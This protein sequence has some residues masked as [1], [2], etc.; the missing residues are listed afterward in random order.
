MLYPAWQLVL[1]LHA[2]LRER[3]GT[4]QLAQPGR[5]LEAIAALERHLAEAGA[6]SNALELKRLLY[7]DLTEAEYRDAVGLE[8]PTERPPVRE[9]PLPEPATPTMMPAGPVVSTM[10]SLAGGAGGVVEET[11]RDLAARASA[12]VPWRLKNLLTRNVANVLRSLTAGPTV[13][14]LP[15][16]DYGYVRELG[17]ALIRDPEK[18]RRGAEFLRIAADGLIAHGPSLLVEIAKAHQRAEDEAGALEYF[19]LARQAGRT[20]GVSALGGADATAY[21]A[22]VKYLAELALFNGDLEGACE[23]FRLLLESPT[24]GVETYRNLADVY[25][26]LG[27]PLNAL[28]YNETAL[29]YSPRDRDLL[30]ARRRYYYSVMPEQLQANLETLRP[31]FDFAYC[32]TRAK[33]ILDN[34]AYADAE[35]LD[36]AVHLMQLATVVESNSFRRA[37]CKRASI[38]AAAN[39]QRR[40]PCSKASANRNRNRSPAARRSRPGTRR[41]RSSAICTWKQADRTPRCPASSPS[42]K[43]I[44][45]APRRCTRWARPTSSS[46]TWRGR[47]SATSSSKATRAIR[48][49]GMRGQA[50][51]P[52]SGLRFAAFV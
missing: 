52:A 14:P 43:A 36:V 44:S 2:G 23:N 21:F 12:A 49:C 28:R 45:A 27:D 6:D 47:S 42:A 13:A 15:H 29:V 20:F 22:T 18:W 39:A 5:R 35:W 24:V 17:L 25:E 19:G 9:T 11:V 7:T 32:L 37:C 40:R 51:A 48:W 4:P 10:Q 8:P 41:S 38:C 1:L 33:N 50:L 34:P 31:C 16:F 30:A 3:V 26:K 46:A